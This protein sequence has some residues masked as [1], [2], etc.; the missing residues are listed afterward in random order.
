MGRLVLMPVRLAGLATAGCGTF[1]RPSSSER[2]DRANKLYAQ[3]SY[4]SRVRA[5]SELARLASEGNADAQYKLGRMYAEGQGA[6]QDDAVAVKWFRKAAAQGIAEAQYNLAN[7]YF[8]GSGVPQDNVQA[9]M[10]ISLAAANSTSADQDDAARFRDEIAAKMTAAEISKAQ[11]F[12]RQRKPGIETPIAAP[13]AAATPG[14]AT[15]VTL[16]QLQILAAP[17]RV[18]ADLDDRLDQLKTLYGRGMITGD[19]YT[20]KRKEIERNEVESRLRLLKD[21]YDQGLI[22]GDDLAERRKEILKSM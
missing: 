5:H 20:E 14:V 1:D 9:Y 3:G 19:E 4:L 13:S 16:Q 6:P 2:L 8:E 18:P 15:P 10:W 12:A 17:V 7:R 11:R 22:S 21:L